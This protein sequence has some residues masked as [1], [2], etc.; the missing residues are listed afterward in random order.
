[1]LLSVDLS[2]F[3]GVIA[4]MHGITSC[5]VSVMGRLFVVPAFMMLSCLIVM[6]GRVG[7]MLR[8]FPMMFG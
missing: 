7:V 3:F 5:R 8:S 4:G 6:T 1:V 2:R